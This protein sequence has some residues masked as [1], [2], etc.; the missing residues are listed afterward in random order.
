M[1]VSYFEPNRTQ[2]VWPYVH[3]SI[4]IFIISGY[5]RFFLY[6]PFFGSNFGLFFVHFSPFLDNSDD[7]CCFSVFSVFF[8]YLRF[9][10]STLFSC[11][12][13]LPYLLYKR[14][15]NICSFSNIFKAKLCSNL[16]FL[17][18]LYSVNY[19]LSNFFYDDYQRN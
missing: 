16:V 4:I 19:I 17:S 3:T 6:F 13:R 10:Y 7:F 12:R 18:I 14:S 15:C 8:S 1:K 11:L 9:S 5:K 2:S